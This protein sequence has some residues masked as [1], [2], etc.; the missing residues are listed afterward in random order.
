MTYGAFLHE[1][2]FV[3]FGMHDTDVYTDPT[4]LAVAYSGSTTI[5]PPDMAPTYGAASLFSTVEDLHRWDQ[6]L[7]SDKL[8]SRDLQDRMFV[9]YAAMDLSPPAD[10]G[11]FSYGYGWVLYSI[12]NHKVI[13][14]GGVTDGVR[15][16][17]DRFPDDGVTVIFLCNDDLMDTD[18]L[19]IDLGRIVLGAT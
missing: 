17:F 15:A 3:P 10:M 2:T 18:A 4:G 14:N 11:P 8:L 6:A 19:L 12:L 13:G 1:H 5:S 7:K 9:P 16:E